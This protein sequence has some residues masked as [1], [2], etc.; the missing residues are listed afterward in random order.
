MV[1]KVI[2]FPYPLNLWP[3]SNTENQLSTQSPVTASEKLTVQVIL[4]ISKK[5]LPYFYACKISGAI[6]A[7]LHSTKI[8]YPNFLQ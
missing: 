1:K 8:L 3:L 7:A 2:H 4:V 6:T 5:V